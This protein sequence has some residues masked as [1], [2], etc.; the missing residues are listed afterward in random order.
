[1][2]GREAHALR[3]FVSVALVLALAVAAFPFGPASAASCSGGAPA[4]DC[5]DAA[6]EWF[7]EPVRL[8]NVGATMEPGEPD[9]CDGEK[10]HASVWLRLEV[11]A[12]GGADHFMVDFDAPF[13][14]TLGAYTRDAGGALSRVTCIATW[15]DEGTHQPSL[16]LPCAAG[17]TYWLQVG[18]Q[19]AGDVGT[20]SLS[21]SRYWKFNQ[22]LSEPCPFKATLPSEPRLAA[23]TP[24]NGQIRVTWTEPAWSGGRDVSVLRYHVY[25]ADACAGPFTHLATTSFRSHVDA[26]LAAGASHCYRVSAENVVGEGPF[27]AARSATTWTPPRPPQGLAVQPRGDGE[28]SVS[29][30]PSPDQAGPAPMS[31]YRVYRADAASGP[32]TLV[33]TGGAGARNFTD[34]GLPRGATA[35]Y[36]IGS[37]NVV[38][39]GAPSDAASGTTWEVP[40]APRDVQ[41]RPVLAPPGIRV[42]WS[43]PSD[44]APFTHYRVYRASSPEG[45]A[46][47]VVEL[48]RAATGYTDGAR[49]VL[50]D[51][52]YEVRASNPAGEGASSA[53][54]CA[55]YPL[56]SP[57]ARCG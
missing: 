15:W 31:A 16:F 37:V 23:P 29:W 52:Y 8:S 11:L 33:G 28:L 38:G 4:N 22:T 24:G 42:T 27:S 50:V 26:G 53:R 46:T 35:Y 55:V 57:L 5:L 2:R 17:A 20:F 9:A 18:G 51:A 49:S 6:N 43:A 44:D 1:M 25:R 39:E 41:A 7:S 47:F 48:P 21:E 3:P 14:A 54:A 13:W 32:F 40:G 30:L 34:A 19:S 10:V 36:R 56:E 45:P 12:P